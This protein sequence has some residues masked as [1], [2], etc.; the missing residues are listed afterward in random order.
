MTLFKPG[1]EVFYAG[2]IARPGCYAKY[3]VLDERI[4]GSKLNSLSDAEAAAL[5]LTS[6]TARGNCCLNAS[7]FPRVVVRVRPC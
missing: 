7:A 2:S 1:D 6:I 4:T 3:S 5:P